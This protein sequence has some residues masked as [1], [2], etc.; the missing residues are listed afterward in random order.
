MRAKRKFKDR[1]EYR[2]A[3]LEERKKYGKKYYEEHKKEILIK[4]KKRNKL[5]KGYYQ[6]HKKIENSTI[7]AIYNNFKKDCG[8]C[9]T[10]K[11]LIIHHWRYRN[12][13]Q[14][15]DFSVVCRS[16]HGIIHA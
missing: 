5:K 8:I 4:S 2:Q 7:R 6:R 11:N 12:P 13:V 10:K 16:C 1:R 3:N 14:R 15:Q 9:H